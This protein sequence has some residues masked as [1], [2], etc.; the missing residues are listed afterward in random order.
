MVIRGASG[1]ADGGVTVDASV[2]AGDWPSP[3]TLAALAGTAVSVSLSRS[4]VQVAPAAEMAVVFTDDAAIRD[5]NRRFR[6]I[7]KPTNVLSFPAGPARAGVYG[8]LLGDVVLAW[9]TVDREA[10]DR[11]VQLKAHL[12]HL[13]VHGFLHL[14]GYDHET[15]AQAV[16]MEALETSIME[17]I[18]M[19]DPY[20]A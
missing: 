5:L 7:D 20:A 10:G 6:D 16:V 19:D 14:V 15:D 9:E 4:G 13:I 8:P 1:Q 3:D 12:T 18:G 17:D 2:V 11:K